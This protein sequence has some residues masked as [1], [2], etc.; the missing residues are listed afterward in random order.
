MSSGDVLILAARAAAF[1]GGHGRLGLGD[2]EPFRIVARGAD[3]GL[4]VVSRTW[5]G[6]LAGAPGRRVPRRASLIR[7]GSRR[8]PASDGGGRCR[9]RRPRSR[10]PAGTTPR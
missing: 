5:S 8:T 4:A 10:R 3:G 1:G 6:S 9:T 2:A 7:S